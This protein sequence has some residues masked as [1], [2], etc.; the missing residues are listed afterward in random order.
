MDTLVTPKK[1]CIS[2]VFFPAPRR[3]TSH[4]SC[5]PLLH[6]LRL[7]HEMI[8]THDPV[9][10]QQK[11]NFSQLETRFSMQ[12]EKKKAGWWQLKY[13]LFSP[14][15][16]G[17]I[18]ILTNIFQMGWFNHQPERFGGKKTCSVKKHMKRVGIHKF[19]DLGFVWRI[20]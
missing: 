2:D 5:F 15:K 19:F 17:K 12:G 18:P 9:L 7:L 13:V 1:L 6:R 16:L 4:K 3:S 20:F 8:R 10:P 14:R 11:Y